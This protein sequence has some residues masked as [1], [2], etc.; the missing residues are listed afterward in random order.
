MMKSIRTVFLHEWAG[1]WRS[2]VFA[3]T[4]FIVGV[5]GVAVAVG[6]YRAWNAEQSERAALQAQEIE[7]WLALDDTHIHKA[8]HRGYFVI[9]N[10]PPGVILDRGVWDFGGSAIWLEAHRR[11]APQLRAADASGLIARGTPRGVGPVLLWL[12]PLL[13]AVLTHGVIAGERARGSLAFAVSSGASP[14]AIVLGKALAVAT[15]AW[16]AATSPILVGAG[17]ALW[18][19]LP[20]VSATVWMLTVLAALGV[21]SILIVMVSSLTRRPLGALVALL[22]IWFAMAVLW[23]RL[24]SGVTAQVSPIPSSQTVRS[25]A[26]VAAEGLVSDSTAQAVRERLAA[27]GVSDPNPSGVSAIA[28]EIDAAQAFTE[29]FAPLEAAMA[30][31]SDLLDVLN[32]A[33]PL[34]TADRAADAALGLSDRHQFSFE[35]RAETMRVATQ[36]TLNEDWA[37]DLGG[38][39]GT[40]ETWRRV[41]EAASDVPAPR[42]GPGYASAG[43]ALWGFVSVAG[44]LWAARAVRGAI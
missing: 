2:G 5:I 38:A 43:L 30:R 23:P 8:A 15:L 17:L 21:F 24:A 26:E 40:P 22:L 14:G 12:T 34:S 32:W 13:I 9:R 31:Q 6:E 18:S 35:A 19:G 39:R 20:L 37:R 33:S 41:V 29:I 1:F 11:N 44:L 28:A 16:A 27:D 10:L 3:L 25:A 42:S 4:A 7:Q 36:M